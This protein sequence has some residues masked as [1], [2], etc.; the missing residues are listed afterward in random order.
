MTTILLFSC[1]QRDNSIT[2]PF[3]ASSVSNPV[4]KIVRTWVYVSD[5]VFVSCFI[6]IN[7]D[8]TFNYENTGC[9]GTV[10]TSGQWTLKGNQLVLNSFETY[11]PKTVTFVT[12][13]KEEVNENKTKSKKTVGTSGLKQFTLTVDPSVLST[14]FVPCGINLDSVTTY[15][16]DRLFSLETDTLYELTGQMGVRSGSKFCVSKNNH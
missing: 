4:D 8:S 10:Y 14:S 13:Q 6:K 12:Q 2:I 15:F 7:S 1:G 3:D 16:K 9:M 11:A 5:N